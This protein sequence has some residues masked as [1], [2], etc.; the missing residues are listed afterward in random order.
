MP[1]TVLFDLDGTLF[2]HDTA[3]EEAI[4][5]SFPDA[6]PE[7]LVP[8]W[9]E[10]SEAAVDRYL[11]GELD[12]TGQR[13]ARIIPLA[14]ELDLGT[15]DDARADAWIADYV[16]RYE[17]AWRP[18]PDARTALE[19]L[20]ASGT[21]LGV[22]TNGQAAQQH[23]KIARLGLADLLPYVLTSSEAGA[24]KPSAAIFHTACEALGLAPGTVAYVGDRLATD[25]RAAASAGL[26]G[27][28][29]DRPGTGPDPLDVPRITTLHALPSVLARR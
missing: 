19:T 27:V 15:W 28:W 5:A 11:A 21:G 3:C 20:A 14:R 10:L 23:A 22:I 8:R 12:F 13:R 17:D 24:A 18:Y 25:A 9:L 26:T 2:D 29:L 6:D 4:L 7:W 16:R 1:S